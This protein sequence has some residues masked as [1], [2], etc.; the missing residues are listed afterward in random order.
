MNFWCAFLVHPEVFIHPPSPTNSYTVKQQRGI[1]LTCSWNQNIYPP[2]NRF[3]NSTV[4]SI[5]P[6][7]CSLVNI[8]LSLIPTCIILRNDIYYCVSQLLVCIIPPDEQL[9]GPDSVTKLGVDTIVDISKLE[10]TNTTLINFF[11]TSTALENDYVCRAE[12]ALGSAQEAISLIVQG[13]VL[14]V[15]VTSFC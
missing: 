5:V 3:R 8:S 1:K 15:F 12:S 9:C 11:K 13:S 2:V 14:N 7:E 10:A 4:A 6:G